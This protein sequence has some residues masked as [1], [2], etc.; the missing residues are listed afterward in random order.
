[1][2]GVVW[3]GCPPLASPQ[4]EAWALGA[5]GHGP[6]FEHPLTAEPLH[7]GLNN[8]AAKDGTQCQG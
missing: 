5:I 8:K 2:Q 3:E 4:C 1:M 7:I 6:A